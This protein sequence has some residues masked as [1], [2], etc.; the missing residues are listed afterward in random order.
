MEKTKKNPVG[1]PKGEPT[2][3]Y[4]IRYN[5]AVIS[6]LKKRYGKKLQTMMQEELE[7]ID[8]KDAD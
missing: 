8:C 1:R 7:R 4:T 5:A 3:R 6:R 2:D